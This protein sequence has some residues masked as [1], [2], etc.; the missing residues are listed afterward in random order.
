MSQ[1]AHGATGDDD[2][3]QGEDEVTWVGAQYL[4]DGF[5]GRACDAPA[6]RQQQPVLQVRPIAVVRTRP[7][8]AKVVRIGPPRMAAP[9]DVAR[10]G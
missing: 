6:A 4:M 1:A 10:A 2:D 5:C 9:V 7:R 3:Q 8:Q